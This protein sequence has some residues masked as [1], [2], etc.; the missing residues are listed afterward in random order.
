MDALKEFEV[1]LRESPIMS[2]PD[3]FFS[4]LIKPLELSSPPA[5]KA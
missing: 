3:A 2:P 4:A 1:T 5:P